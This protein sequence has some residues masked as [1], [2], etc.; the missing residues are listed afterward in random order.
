MLTLD[1]QYAIAC[2]P[3]PG[4]TGGL[5]LRQA[6]VG[7]YML[8]SRLE[9]P[10]LSDP[11]KLKP[12]SLALAIWVLS[13][14]WEKSKKSLG[15]WSAK[16]WL[17]YDSKRYRSDSDAFFRELSDLLNYWQYHTVGIRCWGR[18]NG[19]GGGGSIPAVF[20]IQYVLAQ[21]GC[22][23]QEIFNHSLKGALAALTAY[24]AMNDKDSPMMD[25]GT[26]EVIQRRREQRQ[27]DMKEASKSE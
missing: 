16:F 6:S 1:Q 27:R 8:L 17:K 15:L 9:S 11:L 7:H 21:L 14:P 10:L 13:R 24:N 5:R 22:S 20:S 18:E 23:N 19:G 25:D 2:A 3:G 4:P 12:G 26:L